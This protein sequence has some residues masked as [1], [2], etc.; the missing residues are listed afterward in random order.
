LQKDAAGEREVGTTREEHRRS[1]TGGGRRGDAD[2][3]RKSGESR[4]KGTKG[5]FFRKTLEKISLMRA[6]YQKT[7]R[8]GVGYISTE[9]DNGQPKYREVLKKSQE[10]R[11]EFHSEKGRKK[12][13]GPPRTESGLEKICI[14]QQAALEEDLKKSRGERAEKGGWGQEI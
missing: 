14:P 3:G 11:G 1:T 7:K 12:E 8:E 5:C 2:E 4:G 10:K 13:G 9:G 6:T